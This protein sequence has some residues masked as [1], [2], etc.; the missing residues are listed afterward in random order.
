MIFIWPGPAPNKILF[1]SASFQPRYSESNVLPLKEVSLPWK[2]L[3]IRANTILPGKKRRAIK[4]I[5]QNNIRLVTINTGNFLFRD[6][7]FISEH[8]NNI[9]VTKIA[10]ITPKERDNNNGIVIN[11]KTN[12]LLG[13]Y[14]KNIFK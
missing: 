14:N 2:I 1:C 5:K 6:K 8:I 12:H 13:R 10:A 4:A 11:Q 3:A 9:S 7:S